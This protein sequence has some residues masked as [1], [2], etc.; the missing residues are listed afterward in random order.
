MAEPV[1]GIKQSYLECAAWGHQWETFQPL[2]RRP[3][4]GTLVSLRCV[5]CSS[6]RYDTID[7]TGGLSVR[8]YVKPDDYKPKEWMADKS[9]IRKEVLRRM[10]STKA[11][12]H[13]RAV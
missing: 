6:E 4:W 2:Q 5:R 11:K 7:S 8:S 1:R 9:D 10:R 13:L 3:Q 12:G